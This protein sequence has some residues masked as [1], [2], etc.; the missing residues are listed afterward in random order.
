[1]AGEAVD[2]TWDVR[3]VIAYALAAGATPAEDLRWVYESRG[4][5]V[6]TTFAAHVLRRWIPS[7]VRDLR[8]HGWSAQLIATEEWRLHC[9]AVPPEGN[10]QVMWEVVSSVP[11]RHGVATSVRT[12]LALDGETLASGTAIAVSRE[13]PDGYPV[14]AAEPSAQPALRCLTIPAAEPVHSLAV[15]TA[16]NQSA[17]FRLALDLR[18]DGEPTDAIHIDPAAAKNVGL[19]VPILHAGHIEALIAY[20][21]TRSTSL[22]PASARIE[23]LKPV[24]VGE[25][26]QLDLWHDTGDTS[27]VLARLSDQDGEVKTMARLCGRAT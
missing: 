9:D 5:E 3:S 15:R 4:F 26:L 6:V 10:A 14:G 25:P 21:A 19:S 13:V 20:A 18:A 24:P 22:T 23:Y 12:E 2:V 17:L 7:Y 27:T 16:E 11:W 1:M 8:A